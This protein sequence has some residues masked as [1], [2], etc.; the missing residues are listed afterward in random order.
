MNLGGFWALV[1]AVNAGEVLERASSSAPVEALRIAPFAFL[2]GRID[3][4]FDKIAGLK[5]LAGHLS[6]GT[7]RRNERHEY[8]QTGIHHQLRH[9]GDATDV[10]DAIGLRK[11]KVPIQAVS[12][13][14]AVKEIGVAA[15][16]VQALLDAV[17][18][19]GFS[20]P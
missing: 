10:L 8:D 7:K 18:D 5:Q 1:R 6:L 9:F 19:R 13:V 12:N 11:P 4:H 2:Q 3:E 20:G 17:G 15:F 16:R 14:I